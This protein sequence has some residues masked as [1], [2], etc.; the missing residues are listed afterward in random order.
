[1]ITANFACRRQ[2][3]KLSVLS[4]A[5]G[6]SLAKASG[7]SILQP[8]SVGRIGTEFGLSARSTTCKHPRSCAGVCLC[9]FTQSRKR[10]LHK[11]ALASFRSRPDARKQRVLSNLFLGNAPCALHTLLW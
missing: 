7:C 9:I 6:L 4:E 10:H 1:M 11:R 5:K 2:L 8:P 3:H